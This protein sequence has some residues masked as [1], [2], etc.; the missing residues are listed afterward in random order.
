MFTKQFW[1]RI[2][3]KI[4]R[5]IWPDEYICMEIDAGHVGTKIWMNGHL[6][7]NLPPLSHVY[8][9]STVIPFEK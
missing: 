3:R 8:A 9:Q 7:F 6:L 4:S 2:R 1:Y 5:W